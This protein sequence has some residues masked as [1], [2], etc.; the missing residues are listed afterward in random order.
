MYLSTGALRAKRVAWL[1]AVVVWASV[2][3]LP[4]WPTE[5]V[6]PTFL[7]YRSSPIEQ[8][9]EHGNDWWDV[10]PYGY[11]LFG[12]VLQLVAALALPLLVGRQGWWHWPA[13]VGVLLTTI[14]QFIAVVPYGL[15]N[16]TVVPY[17]AMVAGA[18]LVVAWICVRRWA[19]SDEWPPA[20]IEAS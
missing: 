2:L 14:W 4:W 11:F 3:M 17:L 18:A 1:A 7:E 6:D 5:F 16:T 13:G 15:I 19:E 9:R 10:V 12:F 8:Y 20:R